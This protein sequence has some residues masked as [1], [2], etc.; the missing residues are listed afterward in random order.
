MLQVIA[1]MPACGVP[2]GVLV[3]VGVSVG[4]GSPGVLTVAVVVAVLGCVGLVEGVR[5]GVTVLVRVAVAVPPGEAPKLATRGK[6]S[7]KFANQ[8]DDVAAAVAAAGTPGRTVVAR[9]P[10]PKLLS[11]S[12]AT[13]GIYTLLD[14]GSGAAS[15]FPALYTSCL[16]YTSKRP[17]D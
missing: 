11:R 15:N 14:S 9:L 4:R 16:L 1:V 10:E 12:F 17:R 2:V 5:D 3:A 8:A 7:L 6:C 13:K